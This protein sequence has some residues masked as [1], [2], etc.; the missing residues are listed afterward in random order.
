MHVPF[1]FAFLP[2]LVA[3]ACSSGSSTTPNSGA[4]L[5][6]EL[7]FS[8]AIATSAHQNSEIV[9][10]T[11]QGL[12]SGRVTDRTGRELHVRV[13][14]DGNRLVFVRERDSNDEPSR[15]LFVASIDGSVPETRIT[16]DGTA[17]DGP[18][19]SPDGTRVLFSTARAGG[20]TLWTCAA[21]GTDPRPFVAADP[22]VEDRD[23]DWCA[24]IDRIAFSRR[25]PSGA[26]RIWLVNGDGTGLVPFSGGLAGGGTGVVGDREP[27]FSADGARLAFVRSAG[28]LV[29]RLFVADVATTNAAE[30]FDPQGQ[31]RVPRW[32]PAGDRLFLALAQPTVGR[33]GL[34]LAVL[35]A[36]G[37]LPRL[38]QPD[39]RWQ[40]DG[41]DVLPGL[42]PAPAEGAPLDLDVTRAEVQI[43]AGLVVA[44]TR[45]ELRAADSRELVLVTTTFEDH[46]IAG[47][48]CK[49]T[50]P[51]PVDDVL[52][53]QVTVVARVTRVGGDTAL[54]AT[55]YNPVDE[56]FDTVVELAPGDTGART[57]QFALQSQRHVTRERQV[58]IGVV[59]EIAAGAAAELHVDRVAVAVVPRL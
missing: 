16:A 38:L 15:E 49:F 44:G 12:G 2:L 5:P 58:R 32:S 30:L 46:E 1:H 31:V 22:G 26:M 19:W 50:L 29:D 41:I 3:V 56:R 23:P 59:G 52:A 8:R 27:A 37:G 7:V 36:A 18:C 14:P 35:P 48:N 25:E 39:Q 45:T 51:L 17:D 9:L 40:V 47:I 55:I 33:G 10:R 42:A 20:R 21:D 11:A 13:H 4:N 57:L 6:P 34:R 28:G 54:R 43:A 24:A 53:L